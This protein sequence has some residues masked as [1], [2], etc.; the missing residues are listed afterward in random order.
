MLDFIKSLDLSEELKS[1]EIYYLFKTDSSKLNLHILS[2]L[3]K[4]KTTQDFLNH[5]SNQDFKSVMDIFNNISSISSKLCYEEEKKIFK[6]KFDKYISNISKLI[7]LFLILQ[8]YI[9]LLSNLLKNTK[10]YIKKFYTEFHI[11]KTIKEKINSCINDLASCSILASKRSYS[12]RSTKEST[13]I[14][15]M[16]FSGSCLLKQKQ[17]ENNLSSNSEEFF[18]SQISTPKFEEEEK[19]VI[20]EIEESKINSSNNSKKENN[21]KEVTKENI[22]K[23]NSEKR[24]DSS[25]TLSK[26]KFTLTSGPKETKFHEKAKLN[27]QDGEHERKK[28]KSHKRSSKYK[29]KSLEKKNLII[30]KNN[31]EEKKRILVQ[32]LETIYIL[33]K[34]GEINSNV[35]KSLKRLIVSDYYQM[36][37]EYINFYGNDNNSLDKIVTRENIL[38]F[39]NFY[40]KDI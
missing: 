10:K 34:E 27:N 23:K 39:I 2:T 22:S 25:L 20:A 28:G 12:R 36:I 19:D 7:F 24:C 8:K 29:N 21:N 11:P 40:I 18:F 30:M 32:I 9:E 17:P 3:Q 5:Y 14:P 13:I 35:K 38:K 31:I 26:M 1:D 6:N 33:H 4:F 15:L 37:D 16:K